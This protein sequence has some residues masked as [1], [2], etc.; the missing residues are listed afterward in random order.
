MTTI[1]VSGEV[2]GGRT[3]RVEDTHDEGSGISPEADAWAYSVA[4]R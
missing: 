4:V 3:R 1:E 2:D